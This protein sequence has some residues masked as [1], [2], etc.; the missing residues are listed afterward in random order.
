M[1]LPEDVLLRIACNV[2]SPRS[3][4]ALQQT[5]RSL[6]KL[7]TGPE[8]LPLWLWTRINSPKPYLGTAFS[9][10]R[11]SLPE[12]EQFRLLARRSTP[13]GTVRTTEHGERAALWALPGAGDLLPWLASSLA[14]ADDGAQPLCW[15]LD[16]AGPI[17]AASASKPLYVQ[18]WWDAAISAAVSGQVASLHMLLEHPQVLTP[19]KTVPPAVLA[20]VEA[21]HPVAVVPPAPQPTSQGE[22]QVRK[23]GVWL[24]RNQL[25]KCST[26]RRCSTSV[27][28]IMLH[29]GY[30]I[31]CVEPVVACM[32]DPG[33]VILNHTHAS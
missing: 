25:S 16:A 4:A 22:A 20:T 32:Q 10:R 15:L 1:D 13:E 18:C 31:L 5:S 17:P 24:C 14:A 23:G 21:V 9:H 6:W 3:F 12:F 2:D 11:C 30:G 28:Y 7:V 33:S 19:H 8:L 27:C 26:T 29:H